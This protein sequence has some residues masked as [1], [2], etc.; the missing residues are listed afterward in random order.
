[1]HL[2]SCDKKISPDIA[3][4]AH[5]ARWAK[6]C[7][8]KSRGCVRCQWTDLKIRGSQILKHTPLHRAGHHGSLDPTFWVTLWVTCP[9]YTL[10]L[11]LSLY[12][13]VTT[14]VR[15]WSHWGEKEQYNRTTFSCFS[16]SPNK[17][18]LDFAEKI[19]KL[20][21]KN[22][23]WEILF[24]IQPCY[25]KLWATFRRITKRG[26]KNVGPKLKEVKQIMV[27]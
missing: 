25:F 9:H 11:T 15:T 22:Y 13:Y 10:F 8:S 5:R 17:E 23:S 24:S 2:P 19:C 4:L 7:S 18:L 20:E 21:K 16:V 14:Q 26:E 27:K 3:H 1:M 6:E 12:G